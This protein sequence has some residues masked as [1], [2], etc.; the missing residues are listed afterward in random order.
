MTD[1]PEIRILTYREARYRI[2]RGPGPPHGPGQGFIIWGVPRTVDLRKMIFPMLG[3]GGVF[4]SVYNF[5][6]HKF[7]S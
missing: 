5:E 7:I 2:L 6:E 3:T 4:I 1:K